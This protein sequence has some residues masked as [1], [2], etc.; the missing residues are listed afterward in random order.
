[1]G[2]LRCPQTYCMPPLHDQQTKTTGQP[3]KHLDV[4]EC[5]L[6]D[7]D[8]HKVMELVHACPYLEVLD[9]RCGK[10]TTLFVVQ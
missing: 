7:S 3:V 6:D 5:D 9:L 1:M 2:S 4:S 8:V 10:Q